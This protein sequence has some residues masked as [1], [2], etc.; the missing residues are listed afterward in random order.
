MALREAGHGK[1]RLASEIAPKD[2]L[3]AGKTFFGNPPMSNGPIL[4]T[5]EVL[6]ERVWSEPISKV[7]ASF[8]RIF[9]LPVLL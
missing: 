5:R 4:I 6:Y 1:V 8:A 2:Q 3:E 7:A 9:D